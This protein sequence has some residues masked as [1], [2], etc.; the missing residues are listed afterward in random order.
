MTETANIV[1]VKRD[2]RRGWHWIAKDKY[3]A[4]PSAFD[5]WF[6]PLDHD[7]DGK[8]GGSAPAPSEDLSD[9]RAAYTEKFGKKPFAGWNAETLREKLAAG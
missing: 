9:L 5:L 1:R 6:D 8:P 3:E 2:G 4:D 7:G